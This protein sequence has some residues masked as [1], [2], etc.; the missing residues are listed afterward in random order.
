M[1][2][3]VVP[4][5][6]PGGRM[7]ANGNNCGVV[8]LRDAS[9]AE[10]GC[11]ECISF[12]LSISPSP[13]STLSFVYKLGSRKASVRWKNIPTAPTSSYYGAVFVAQTKERL[14]LICFTD[15][16]LIIACL[17]SRETK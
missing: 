3:K 17:F 12:F 11:G 10:R 13:S 1:K 2:K 15:M 16:C 5:R 14:P 4:R 8:C 7:M 9:F 6:I